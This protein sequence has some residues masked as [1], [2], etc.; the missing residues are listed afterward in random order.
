LVKDGPLPLSPSRRL[1]EGSLRIG[2]CLWELSGGDKVGPKVFVEC[3]VRLEHRAWMN[4]WVEDTDD[5]MV[6]LQVQ[7]YE[8]LEIEP[9]MRCPAECAE[10]ESESI[11]ISDGSQANLL[12]Q[13][14][15]AG[16]RPLRRSY[17]GG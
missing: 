11:H 9:A 16:P 13:N 5:L 10:V 6:R 2:E 4:L 17:S 8:S 15:H 12:D 3:R 1:G 14:F 7:F